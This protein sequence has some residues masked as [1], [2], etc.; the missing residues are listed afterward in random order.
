MIEPKQ[1]SFDNDCFPGIVF[2]SPAMGGF[3]PKTD[4]ISAEENEK[5][6]C[7]SKGYGREQAKAKKTLRTGAR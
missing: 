6:N 5:R 4:G 3:D 1:A 7:F 2:R